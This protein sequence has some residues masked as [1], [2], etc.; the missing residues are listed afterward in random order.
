MLALR[1]HWVAAVYLFQGIVFILSF[2]RLCVFDAKRLLL[3]KPDVAYN[4]IS[5][6]PVYRQQNLPF[7]PASV[8]HVSNTPILVIRCRSLLKPLPAARF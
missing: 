4:T 7:I 5:I 2:L 3:R 1:E 8:S 6:R